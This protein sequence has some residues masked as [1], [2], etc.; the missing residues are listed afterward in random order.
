MSYGG[1]SHRREEKEAL[2]TL[3][4]RLGQ[5]IHKV[6]TAAD[7]GGVNNQTFTNLFKLM[8]DDLNAL[9]KTYEREMDGLR[10]DENI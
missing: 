4:D 10:Y 6:R 1:A 9:R 3:N 7:T 8:E 2:K 5:Y